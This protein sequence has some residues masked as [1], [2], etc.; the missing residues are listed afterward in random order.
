MDKNIY[1]PKNVVA[2]LGEEN[3]RILQEHIAPECIGI[4][5]VFSRH[6][7]DDVVAIV[8]DNDSF[9]WAETEENYLLEDRNEVTLE[10]ILEYMSSVGLIKPSEDPQPVGDEQEDDVSVL[11]NIVLLNET[12]M[13]NGHFQNEIK[14]L[15]LSQT[16][17]LV[18]LLEKHCNEEYLWSIRMYMEPDS[19]W[20][21]TVYR[22][23]I[24]QTEQ[25]IFNVD[26]ITFD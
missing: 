4:Y 9:L 17:K 11:I 2:E 8:I 10:E 5:G 23:S 20:S 16:K 25:M 15:S 1:I 18:K 14:Q 26:N 22:E 6:T 24:D 13:Y 3:Y 12:N 21:C 7:E 19:R